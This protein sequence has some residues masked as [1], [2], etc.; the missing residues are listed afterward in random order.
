MAAV[1]VKRSIVLGQLPRTRQSGIGVPS[2]TQQNRG[3]M[4]TL[5]K[6]KF[7]QSCEHQIGVQ[8]T[9]R[10]CMFKPKWCKYGLHTTLNAFKNTFEVLQ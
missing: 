7:L 6:R 5:K 3:V 8:L 4:V 1:S 9:L 10:S 2:N